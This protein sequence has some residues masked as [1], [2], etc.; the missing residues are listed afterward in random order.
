M[1]LIVEVPAESRKGSCFEDTFSQATVQIAGLNFVLQI[2]WAL[3]F[4]PQSLERSYWISLSRF[5]LSGALCR[6]TSSFAK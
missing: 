2:L 1:D 5:N 6:T 4:K 3:N